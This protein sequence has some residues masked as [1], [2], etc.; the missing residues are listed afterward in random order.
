ME[1]DDPVKNINLRKKLQ[2]EGVDDEGTA[3][4]PKDEEQ[5]QQ[6]Q[7]EGYK[8]T[9]DGEYIYLRPIPLS[10]IGDR[11]HG[12][13]GVNGVKTTEMGP[14]TKDELDDLVDTASQTGATLTCKDMK[15]VLA[16]SDHKMYKKLKLGTGIGKL[17]IL[18]LNGGTFYSK[19]MPVVESNSRCRPMTTRIEWSWRRGR[20]TTA[21]TSTRPCV[22][23]TDDS[24]YGRRTYA[25]R[26]ERYPGLQCDE[27]GWVD[28]MDFLHHGWVFDH[29]NIRTEDDGLVAPEFREERVNTMIKTVW[30]EFQ[31]KNKVRIQ[32]L[33]IVLDSNFDKPDAYLDQECHES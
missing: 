26:S 3:K 2:G 10:V 16:Y 24:R 19:T 17:K 12:E 20:T 30:S 8:A 29:E 27:A 23:I 33:C 13:K 7:Q 14:A 18:P 32:F 9:R 31:K 22:T 21:T 25:N 4:E 6:Q 28:I 11:A 5:Q 15:S 1:G